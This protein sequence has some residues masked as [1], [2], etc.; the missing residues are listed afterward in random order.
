VF[1]LQPIGRGLLTALALV[2]FL[3]VPAAAQDDTHG[4]VGL[5]PAFLS[6]EEEYGTLAKGAAVDLAHPFGSP[7]LRMRWVADFG[8]MWEDDFVDS[9]VLGGVRFTIPVGRRFNIDLQALLGVAHWEGLGQGATGIT[10][11]P[12]AAV[13]FWLNDRLGVKGQI[14]YQIPDWDSGKIY[15]TWIALVIGLPPG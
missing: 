14:D 5:G 4:A 15:R 10:G 8:I 7:R 12:G 11:G 6:W 2:L 9:L 13:R 3:A 1:V